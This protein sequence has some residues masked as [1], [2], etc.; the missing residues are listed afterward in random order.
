MAFYVARQ[1]VP[2]A[3]P[4]FGEVYEEAKIRDDPGRSWLV[5]G[6]DGKHGLP[7]LKRRPRDEAIDSQ[8]RGCRTAS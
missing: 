1:Q 5:F 8:S 3:A 7:Y 2:S 6:R 4:I